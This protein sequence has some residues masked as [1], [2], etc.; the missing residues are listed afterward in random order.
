MSGGKIRIQH[1]LATLNDTWFL[2]YEYINTGYGSVCFEDLSKTVVACGV[3]SYLL[4]SDGNAYGMIS[5][6]S[7]GLNRKTTDIKSTEPYLLKT[8]RRSG[9]LKRSHSLQKGAV[10]NEW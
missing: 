8:F 10:V 6:R 4:S 2:R 3:Y 1:H 9:S 5:L 7:S